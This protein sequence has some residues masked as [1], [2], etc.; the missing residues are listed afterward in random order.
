M[1][2]VSRFGRR[3]CLGLLIAPALTAC[4]FHPVY[5]PAASGADS[6]AATGL[7]EIN[8]A[9][10]PERSGQELRLALQERFERSGVAVARRYDLTVTFGVGAEAIGIQPD[11]SNTYVRLIGSA[12]YRLTAQDPTRSTLTSGIARSVEGF[13]VFDQ[14]FFAQDQ[15]TDAIIKRI[16]EAIADQIALQLALYFKK[17]SA[18]AAG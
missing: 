10:I 2:G 8:V 7:A 14:Q 9:L 4:G 5:A 6:A 17:Q 13:N 1:G 11:T 18:T 15:E 16:A 3:A 12:T